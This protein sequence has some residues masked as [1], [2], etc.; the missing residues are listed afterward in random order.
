MMAAARTRAYE[1]VGTTNRVATADPHQLIA[2]LFDEALADLAKARRAIETDD[3][4]G[5]SRYL[6]HASTLVAALEVSLDYDKGGEI[7]R[8]L[9]QVYRFIRARILTAGRKNDPEQARM[10]AE[11]LGEI[12]SAWTSIR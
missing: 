12:A 2:I 8:T 10:A 4:A 6:S 1:T 9:G 11:T 3:L 5:K 7:A